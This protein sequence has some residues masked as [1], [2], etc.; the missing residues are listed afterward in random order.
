MIEK[1]ELEKVNSRIKKAAESSCFVIA[2]MYHDGEEIQKNIISH[3]CSNIMT[4]GYMEL[5]KSIALE[6]IKND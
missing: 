4:L 5:L 2:I 1:E 3:N 6:N